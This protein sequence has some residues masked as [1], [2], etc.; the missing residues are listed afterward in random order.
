M[1]SESAGVFVEAQICPGCVH[2][3][4][5][6]AALAA[7]AKGEV[8][9]LE[10]WCKTRGRCAIQL[11]GPGGVVEL[12][13][14]M[15]PPPPA[16]DTKYDVYKAR[17]EGGM[18]LLKYKPNVRIPTTVYETLQL[19]GDDKWCRRF[20]GRMRSAGRMVPPCRVC[21]RAPCSLKNADMKF[22]V[23]IYLD[24][25]G[26]TRT[27]PDMNLDMLNTQQ[28]PL[29]PPPKTTKYQQVSMQPERAP[30]ERQAWTTLKAPTEGPPQPPQPPQQQKEQKQQQPPP[31]AGGKQRMLPAPPPPPPPPQQR[32]PSGPGP[33]RPGYKANTTS[34]AGSSKG[35]R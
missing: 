33:A 27:Q 22:E 1:W 19:E 13:R 25:F 28:M 18:M 29:L 14:R 31:T 7:K 3:L 4:P 9:A 24:V 26:I 10:G 6:A 16:I 5:S 30:M 32:G 21:N 12:R 20:E 23:Q 2:F 11:D 35:G 34:G 17:V 15:A 8:D